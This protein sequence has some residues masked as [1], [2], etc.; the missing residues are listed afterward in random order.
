MRGVSVALLL[1]M[2]SLL[3]VAA[4]VDAPIAEGFGAPLSDD[5]EQAPAAPTKSEE[6]TAEEVEIAGGEE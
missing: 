5:A 1:F 2:S 6:P 4:A 3:P